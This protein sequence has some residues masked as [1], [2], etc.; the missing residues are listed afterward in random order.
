MPEISRRTAKARM[1]Q[2]TKSETL[3]PPSP[4]KAR[5]STVIDDY[6]GRMVS[7][8]YRWLED[9][10]AE[11]TRQ[12]VAEQNGYT[13]SRLEEFSGRKELRGRIERLMTIGRVAS[14]RQR[15]STN[16]YE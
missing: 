15:R 10:T 11:E 16:F 6:H 13:R 1:N 4:P 12:F 8:P 9:S 2:K 3:K 14:P 5:V 7:D